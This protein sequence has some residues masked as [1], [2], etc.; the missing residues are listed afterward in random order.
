MVKLKNKNMT[1]EATELVAEI[2]LTSADMKKI[3]S[4]RN[5]PGVQEI[6]VMSSVGGS[7]L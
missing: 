2:M 7:V 1:A 6:T 4:L 3:E 5:E